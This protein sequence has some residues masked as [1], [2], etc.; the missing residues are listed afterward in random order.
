[1]ELNPPL[2]RANNFF[3]KKNGIFCPAGGEMLC[4]VSDR[5]TRVKLQELRGAHSNGT[6]HPMEVRFAC[7]SV[8]L[9]LSFS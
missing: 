9:F 4:Q 2:M 6:F 3:V 8:V 7:G 5:V 1:N